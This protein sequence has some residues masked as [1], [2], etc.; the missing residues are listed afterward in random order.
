MSPEVLNTPEYTVEVWDI[1]GVFVMDI[2]DLIATSLR[3]TREVNTV[4][5]ISF[6]IDLVQFELRCASVGANPRSI[7]EPYRTDIKIR[8]NGV[9]LVG[10]QVVQA[11][12]NFNQ[13]DTNK[14]EIKC[15]GYLNYFKDRF[16]SDFY[17]N[18]TYAQMARQLITDT[19]SQ[20]NLISNSHF[21]TDVGGWFAIDSGYIAWDANEG[22]NYPG[23]LYVSVTTGPNT[24]G[25]ARWPEG[26]LAGVTYTLSFKAKTTTTGGNIYYDSGAGVAGS[27]AVSTTNWTPYTFTWTQAANSS[28]IDIKSTGSMNFYLDDVKL[29]SSLDNPA[30]FDF[31]V[32]LGVDNASAGQAATRQRTYDLQNVKDGIVNLTKLENDNFDFEFTANKVFNIYARLGSDKPEVELV[33]PQNITSVR[34]TRDASTLANRIIGLGSGIGSERLETVATGYSSAAAYRIRERT[35][36]FNSVQE[37]STL[38]AN[39]FGKLNVYETM[40][41]VPAL[42]VE[43]NHL[44]LDE[45]TLG[46]AITI[47]IDNSSFVNTI[48]GMWR[49]MKM[50]INVDRDMNES[51]SLDVEAW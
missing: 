39:T 12:I 7:I 27:T 30:Y 37:Q 44:D 51:V 1:N 43:A 13:Q 9:Y 47:R 42:T 35:E 4:E 14:I 24:F 34:V 40:Y 20:P 5:D 6:A 15:T 23:S 48:N 45:V 8:R 32:T 28:R 41:E 36:T 31:G 29:T 33:Y 46:D 16:I 25:G 22:Y 38:D 50:T 26:L 11:N 17:R 3:I 18:K 21:Y 49:I 19:Q 10:G 2:S